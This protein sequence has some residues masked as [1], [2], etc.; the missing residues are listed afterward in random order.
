MDV[1][2]DHWTYAPYEARVTEI[3]LSTTLPYDAIGAFHALR[4]FGGGIG[5]FQQLT[6]VERKQVTRWRRRW[7]LGWSIL[8]TMVSALCGTPFLHLPM[9]L[10][11]TVEIAYGISVLCFGWLLCDTWKAKPIRKFT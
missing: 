2:D 7:R 9:A 11:M 10:A 5:V 3:V 8:I 6:Q 1:K 4:A